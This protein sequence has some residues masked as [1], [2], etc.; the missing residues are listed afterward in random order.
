[1]SYRIG[2]YVIDRRKGELG[3]VMGNNG[4]YLLLRR[5]CGGTE[6]DCPPSAAR[7]ATEAERHAA[8]IAANGATRDRAE[9]ARR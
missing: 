4:P 3:R 9:G 7:L 6:W 5:P 8:G 2:A 1:M